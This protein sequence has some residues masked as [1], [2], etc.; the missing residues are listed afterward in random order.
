M[1][2]PLHNLCVH[3]AFHLSLLKFIL[4][5]ILNRSTNLRTH[6]NRILNH[7]WF[8]VYIM[9]LGSAQKCQ[10]KHSCALPLFHFKMTREAAKHNANMLKSFNYDLHQAVAAQSNLPISYGS[11]FQPWYKLEPLLHHHPLW[12]HTKAYL[13]DSVTFPLVPMPETV[14]SINKEFML[15]KGKSQISPQEQRNSK[16]VDQ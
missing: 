12:D 7:S 11:E 6:H 9:N 16:R 15:A 1:A 5:Y 13:K 14:R 2:V 8:R 4:S 10:S 3:T